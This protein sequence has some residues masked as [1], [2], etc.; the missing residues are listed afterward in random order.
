MTPK[1]VLF[2]CDGVIVDSEPPTF[3][4][5]QEEFA[6]HGLDLDLHDLETGWAGATIEILAARAMGLGAK[7]PADWVPGFYARLNDRFRSGVPLIAGVT[8]VLDRLDAAGVR[9]AIGSNGPLAKMEV[10]LGQHGLA[11]RFHGHIHSG[12]ALGAPKPAPD[13][14]LQAAAGLGV[15]PQDC[16][17]VEDSGNGALAA[18]AAGMTCYGYAPLG[19]VTGLAAAGAIL[20]AAMPDLP[21]LI[22]L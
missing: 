17:V 13:V 21:G 5:L 12:Q 2:D 10:T 15:M 18:R 8:D 19:D 9:Y 14:Y 4:L 7:L 16:V 3:R 22:G 1:A 6:A 11:Q 20:F